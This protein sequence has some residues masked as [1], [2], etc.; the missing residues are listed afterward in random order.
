VRRA[1]PAFVAPSDRAST[2]EVSWD[3]PGGARTLRVSVSPASAAPKSFP[4]PSGGREIAVLRAGALGAQLESESRPST[5]DEWIE[6]VRPL[7]PEDSSFETY[8]DSFVSVEASAAAVDAIRR[9]LVEGE[10]AL[11]GG[12]V[13]LRAVAVAEP[14]LRRA[15]ERG[16]PLVGAALS[17]EA[18][19]ALL[20]SSSVVH[21]VRVPVAAEVSAGFRAGVAELMLDDFGVEVAQQAGG[22]DPE[23]RGGF[24]GLAG[25]V[26]L[27]PGASGLALEVDG[28]LGWRAADSTIELAFRPPVGMQFNREGVKTE[29]P[30]ARRVALPFGSRG[31]AFLQAR[32]TVAPEALGRPVVL[33]VVSRQ[34]AESLPDH[35][36]I[37]A[38]VRR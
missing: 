22:L 2:H 20:A 33:A 29:D 31:G 32:A 1:F 30:A 34:G 13:E 4:L 15:L 6:S 16:E 19:S 24:T 12:V 10:R 21:A 18:E 5:L 27:V 17:P 25:T 14:D 9:R 26:R 36:L 28:I 3:G 37:L 38:T 7:A 11:A 23:E 8:G 35:L